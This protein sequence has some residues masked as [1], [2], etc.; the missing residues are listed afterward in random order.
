M[1]PKHT[2]CAPLGHPWD[3]LCSSAVA[4]YPQAEMVLVL[5]DAASRAPS[6]TTRWPPRTRR[7]A[8][9]S[10]SSGW[11][12]CWA[13]TACS[14]G[15]PPAG[16]RSEWGFPCQRAL[17]WSTRW[18]TLVV[19]CASLAFLSTLR[20]CQGAEQA[21]ASPP[22]LQHR[23]ACTPHPGALEVHG[24]QVGGEQTGCCRFLLNPPAPSVARVPHIPVCLPGPTLLRSLLE[25]IEQLWSN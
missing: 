14:R 22:T 3:F 20:Q 1:A 9:R 18:F 19:V 5:P 17:K 16:R 21:C 7:P 11:P 8:G 25:L 23:T 15:R 12:V 4:T 2:G 10:G 24:T 13:A 6:P